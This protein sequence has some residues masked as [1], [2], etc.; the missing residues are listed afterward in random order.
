[1]RH[2]EEWDLRLAAFA[3]GTLS[4]ADR[5]M[6]AGHLKRCTEC[7]NALAAAE[8]GHG[9]LA[10]WE[11]LHGQVASPE[12][13]APADFLAA[14]ERRAARAA[15]AECPQQSVRRPAPGWLRVWAGSDQMRPAA[16]FVLAL[17]LLGALL[18]PGPTAVAIAAAS[19]GLG[20]T[21]EFLM[22]W[23]VSQHD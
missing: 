18:H 13:A 17:P 14:V 8:A 15:L 19:L 3:E 20:A 9:A 23:E 12:T 11:P 7:R 4:P 21:L 2:G 6:V 10:R 5:R 16:W 22:T 1:M